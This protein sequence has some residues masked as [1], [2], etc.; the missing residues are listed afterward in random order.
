MF[1]TGGGEIAFKMSKVKSKVEVDLVGLFRAAFFK[2][3]FTS[4]AQF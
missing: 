1:T 3:L 4:Y 2:L